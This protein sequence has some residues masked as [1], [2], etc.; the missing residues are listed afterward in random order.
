MGY[1][2]V[3]SC[4]NGSYYVGSTRN[5]YDRLGNHRNGQVKYTKNNRPLKLIFV[6]EFASYNLAYKFEMKVKSW[7]KRSSIEKMIGKSDNVCLK[8]CGIVSAK[9]SDEIAQLVGH[10]G[11]NRN[12]L[13]K[14]KI[15]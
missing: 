4:I 8:Y 3:L 13:L 2:Y 1:C 15:N 5:I 10:S 9:H 7:K 12:K 14:L 6:K 11:V